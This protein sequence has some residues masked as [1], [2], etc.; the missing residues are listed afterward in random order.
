MNSTIIKK[1]LLFYVLSVIALSVTCVKVL[2]PEIPGTITLFAPQQLY[3]TAA[4]IV[5]SRVTSDNF[6]GYIVYYD[7]L[8]GVSDSS[9]YATLTIYKNDT[10]F[11]LSGLEENTTY[12][13]KVFAYN[14][15]AYRE[16][17][18]I[19]FSTQSCTCGVFTGDQQ[20][21]MALIPAGC[22]IS[23]DSSVAALTHDYFM[24]TTEVTEV[25]WN[26]VMST[27]GTD[28]SEFSEKEWNYIL[29]KNTS[30]AITPK[31]DIS[32]YQ[33]I[34]F[35]NEKSKQK[36]KDTCFIYTAMVIDT[37]ATAIAY[38]ADLQC[39]FVAEGFRLPTEDEW[40][41]AY[42]TGQQTEYYWG[43][44]GNTSP[45][46]PYDKTYPVSEE[47]KEE[48]S[49]YV[50]WK[51]NN[52]PNG[53]KEIVRKKDNAWHLY[54]MAGNVKEFV[55]DLWSPTR[56][57]NRI[58]YTGP[59]MGP[60]STTLHIVR[61]GSFLD[62]GNRPVF[63]AWWRDDTSFPDMGSYNNGFRTVRTH[64]IDE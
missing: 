56:D 49:E 32:W 60:S 23:R 47:D 35:C 39:S 12:Y 29:G 22:F 57:K 21:G 38:F 40:E 6:S 42:R 27:L 59:P 44:D 50:W 17:N 2:D 63:T 51:Y 13:V 30:T 4:E 52:N 19:I 11:I 10:S 7:T 20:D 31:V 41:Y 14:S 54:D 37:D 61:G 36:G 53:P 18:E 15:T 24:D 33:I 25:E 1:I 64:I 45:D 58:D 28:T 46:F 26:R 34:L 43:R 55:W 16:S 8:P 48:M 9:N 62:D 5:W 3:A